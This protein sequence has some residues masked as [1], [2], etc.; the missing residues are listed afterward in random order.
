MVLE[1]LEII[2]F[3]S[4]SQKTLLRFSKGIT[5]IVGPNGCGK[6]NILDAV[7]W[8]LGSRSVKSLRGDK[9]E[10]II[11]S[12]SQYK[13]KSNYAQVSL[14]INNANGFFKVDSEKIEL[15]RRYYRDSHGDVFINRQKV[16]VKELENFLMDT[17]LGKSCYSFMEQGKIDM[18]LSSRPEDRRLVFE[19]AAG[20]SRFKQEQQ[21]A[22]KKLEST[23]NNITRIRDIL[24]SI[25]KEL[26][27]KLKQAGKSLKYAQLQKEYQSCNLKIKFILLND[28]NEQHD[29]LLKKIS[30]KNV[31]AEKNNQKKII[32]EES[33]EENTKNKEILIKELYDKRSRLNLYQREKDQITDTVRN[34]NKKIENIKSEKNH[35]EKKLRTIEKFVYSLKKEEGELRQKRLYLHEQV[36]D[37]IAFKKKLEQEITSIKKNI[38]QKQLEVANVE[39][40]QKVLSLELKEQRTRHTSTVQAL[41]K[42]LD[43]EKLNWLKNQKEKEKCQAE[44][45]SEIKTF[46]KKLEAW[47]RDKKE[48]ETKILDILKSSK[49]QW[50]NMIRNLAQPDKAL[51]NLFFGKESILIQKENLDNKISAL[52]K[53]LENKQLSMTKLEKIIKN[54]SSLQDSKN[55]ELSQLLNEIQI[56]DIQ[57]QNVE[58]KLKNHTQQYH[59][60][61]EQLNYFKKMLLREEAQISFLSE[62]S[63]KL[64]N[65]LS[66][67]NA[68]EKQDTKKVHI[69]AEKI[70]KI[71]IK[72]TKMKDLISD[73]NREAQ[74]TMQE[75]N[76]LKIRLETAQIQ[77]NN[78]IQ[79]VYNE[80]GLQEDDLYRKFK[81]FRPQLGKEQERLK[82]IRARISELGQVNPM[83]SEELNQIQKEHDHFENQLTD[84]L[85]SK[86]NIMLLIE[87]SLEERKKRF[88][89]IFKTVEKNSQ[90]IFHELFNGGHISLTLQ[91]PTKPL[92]CGVEINVQM[93]GSRRK[94]I[95]LLSGGERALVAIALMFAIYMV[96]PSPICI[97]DEI[98]AS[99]D[100]Q[101]TVKLLELI[102]EFKDKAQF[103]LI[104]HNKLTMSKAN[105]LLGVTM[106][107]PG[108]SKLV[109]LSLKHIA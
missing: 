73:L 45:E 91:D 24:K 25:G 53:D 11:F 69:L 72:H 109:E 101:N 64:R 108:I 66:E 79:D 77:K 86:D 13:D 39:K 106:E 34:N 85:K 82:S 22:T 29:L 99:L 35:L 16:P 92:E 80:H 83:A 60:E 28:L 104:T 68:K 54:Q 87:D 74:K 78:V 4:F 98:D 47:L 81:N 37:K 10:D 20:I 32:M 96:K 33:L 2:G 97:L 42:A 103:I 27:V 40:Q 49:I 88:L 26:E 55:K 76:D 17:G 102:N 67:S 6:S 21:E 65:R 30:Q 75:I 61:K 56:H 43:S 95:S 90:T 100:D 23:C 8:V 57:N 41:L 58:E 36:E 5:A 93:P 107:E 19:E 15:T 7:K 94:A 31:L 14:V 70:N 105:T 52:E 3:K 50:K 18:I 48:T 1:F 71:N 44:F 38:S 12:G 51:E 62:D 46:F 59:Q 84:I 63:Q 89:N 9:M